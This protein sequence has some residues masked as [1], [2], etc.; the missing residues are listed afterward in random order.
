MNLGILKSVQA[1]DFPWSH[2]LRE[3]GAVSSNLTIPT[4]ISM[5]YDTEHFSYSVQ[6]NRKG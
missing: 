5:T 4:I 6:M 2:C 3:A 1:L